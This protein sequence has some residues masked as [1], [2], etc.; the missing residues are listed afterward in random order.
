MEHIWVNKTLGVVVGIDFLN[1]SELMISGKNE[2]KKREILSA[3]SAAGV[4]VAFGAPIG[5]DP[6]IK[7]TGF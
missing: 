1:F 7:Q 2:A 5:K 4:S 6:N 3:A